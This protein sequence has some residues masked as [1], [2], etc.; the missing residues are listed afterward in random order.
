M[1]TSSLDLTR[2]ILKPF[3]T[4]LSSLKGVG[5]ATAKLLSKAVGGERVIDLLFHTPDS[6]INRSYRPTLAL[7]EPGRIV[8]VAGTI[9]K[10]I[11]PSRPRKPTRA[12]FT[13]GTDQIELILFSPYQAKKLTQ[14]QTIALSGVL[15]AQGLNRTITNPEHLIPLSHLEEGLEAIPFIEAVWPLTAGLFSSHISRTL[16]QAFRLFPP[17]P[18][19]EWLPPSLLQEYN[20]PGFMTALHLLHFPGDF[21][22]LV[23]TA[24]FE[25]TYE[26]AKNRLAFDELFSGQLGMVIARAHNHK[27][28]GFSMAGTESGENPYRKEALKRFGYELTGAQKRVLAEIDADMAAPRRMQRLLQGDVGSGKTII[29]LLSMLQAYSSGFQAALMAP[30]EILARQHYET[31]SALCP[32]PVAYLSG[33]IKGVQR[34]KLLQGVSMGTIPIVIGTHALFQDKVS[35]S[36]LGLSIIDEQHRFG[37]E[38]RLRLNEKGEHTDTLAMTATPIP[39]TL[40]LTQ[41][42]EM[43]VSRIDELPPG[44]KPIKTT[45]HPF[46]A[47]KDI[48]HRLQNPLRNGVQA[49]WVCPLV[50]ESEA[51][52]L[53]AAEERFQS[54]QQYF[55]P[56]VVGLVHGQQDVH[57]RNQILKKFEK[58]DLSILVATTVIEV[59]VNI[60]N[61]SIMIVEHAERFGLAQLHQLRGRVGRGSKASYC[62]LLHDDQLS[63]TSQRRLNILRET[64]DG[65]LIAE[66]DFRL[67]GGGD[68]GG[69]RQT[70]FANFH[71]A[72]PALLSSYVP[73]ARK[74][75]THLI[76]TDPSLSTFLGHA[77]QI[78]LK[79]FGRD[80]TLRLLT[81]G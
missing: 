21:P 43:D 77:A 23:K 80:E 59:G 33:T 78:P 39:R 15:E 65:F 63:Y 64:E 44:R 40:L 68:M 48:I 20:W 74:L 55:G 3:L 7:A 41:Y 67:R 24:T 70:G 14:S 73:L 75:A 51:L 25:P 29:A 52:D 6:L 28:H 81:S 42:G 76:H 34:R 13:D 22:E 60:P 66:E 79:L 56:D 10:I 26:K 27:G 31:F 5:P 50:Q 8:T 72:S 57:H 53:A 17:E 12:L 69:T 1:P 54:L 4:P 62:L 58:G 49:F 71:F 37:V 46:S 11:S 32:I 61:A 45:L 9:I 38:Q 36:R 30:T 19:P 18:L 16:R 47:T 35:F 2:N